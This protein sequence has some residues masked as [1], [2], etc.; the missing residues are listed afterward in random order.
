MERLPMNNDSIKE[1]NDKFLQESVLDIVIE[2]TTPLDMILQ[3]VNN[4]VKD[5]S[6]PDEMNEGGTG[7]GRNPEGPGDSGGSAPGP[8][9]T[10]ETTSPLKILKEMVDAKLQCPCNKNK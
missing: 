9:V 7:S 2:E 10:F 4:N 6:G 8:L 3:E 1:T 5:V